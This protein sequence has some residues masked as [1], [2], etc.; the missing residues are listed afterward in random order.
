MSTAQKQALSASMKRVEDG[1][2]VKTS[3]P[4]QGYGMNP[5]QFGPLRMISYK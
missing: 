1:G 4:L 3:K 5:W 2:L